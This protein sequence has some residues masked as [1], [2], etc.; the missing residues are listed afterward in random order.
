MYIIFGV[1][2]GL[3]L[4]LLGYAIYNCCCWEY[5]KSSFLISLAIII[6]AVGTCGIIH[7]SKEVYAESFEEGY[8]QIDT[9]K[10]IVNGNEEVDKFALAL[11]NEGIETFKIE[12]NKGKLATEFICI[13]EKEGKD[14]T[15]YMDPYDIKEL[16][17][18]GIIEQ[19]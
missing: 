15:F 12:R 4:F 13:V 14:L 3:G 1:L 8:Y 2:M 7:H 11:K 5:V 16:I 17:K 19:Y 9:K 18:D 10:A 6:T